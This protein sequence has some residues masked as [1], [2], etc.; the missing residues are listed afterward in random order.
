MATQ[1][2]LAANRANALK[3]TG[4]KTKKG[5]SVS[6]LNA[7]KHG[8]QA[9][10]LLLPGEDER[11][12]HDLQD[13]LFEA[14]APEDSLEIGLAEQVVAAMWRLRR[15]YRIEVGVI[16]AQRLQVQAARLCGDMYGD[17]DYFLRDKNLDIVQDD[18]SDKATSAVKTEMA[19]V[20]VQ[21]SEELPILGFSFIKDADGPNA[22]TK[23]SRYET[24]IERSL[25]RALRELERLRER[26]NEHAREHDNVIDMTVG[27]DEDL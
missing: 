14:L 5:K 13:E 9:E 4:P 19:S 6:K 26:R 2:Q 11:D 7:M 1:K 17:N 27:A 3:S 20:R 23:L 24:S 18:W 22:L 15:V 8:L 16:T 12:F 21:A 25:Y 10:H